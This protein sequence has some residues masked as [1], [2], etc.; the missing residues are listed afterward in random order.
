MDNLGIE[1]F[2]TLGEKMLFNNYSAFKETS[3]DLTHFE[4]GIYFLRFSWKE[5]TVT[6]KLVIT[7]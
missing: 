5:K 4:K 1:L 3:L 2:N 7:D 6:E